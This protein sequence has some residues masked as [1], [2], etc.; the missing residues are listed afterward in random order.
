MGYHRELGPR[1]INRRGFIINAGKAA[2]AAAGFAAGLGA[3]LAIPR[4]PSPDTTPAVAEAEN[5]PLIERLNQILALP[6]NTDERLEKEGTYATW[7]SDLEA[8]DKGLWVLS[9]P[10]QRARLIYK[11]ATLREKGHPTLTRL[12]DAQ[13]AWA[14]KNGIHPETLA[15][16]IDAFDPAKE[17]IEKLK[18]VLR[19]N[20]PASTPSED[21][22]INPGGMA[23]LMVTESG[24]KLDPYP[25]NN[26]LWRGFVSIGQRPAVLEINPDKFPN[27]VPALRKLAENLRKDTGLNFDPENIQ[28]S[29]RGDPQVNDSGGAIGLQF[30][31]NNALKL[32]NMLA[33]VGIKFNPFDIT[34]SLVGGWVFL[35]EQVSFPDGS[36]RYGYQRGNPEAIRFAIEKWNQYDPQIRSIVEAAYDYYDTIIEPSPTR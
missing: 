2:G 28:G 23:M 25:G 22:M 5:P 36:L 8:I 3:G 1:R 7:A 17:A 35:A 31:P 33:S 19:P 24:F 12:S 32:Y 16:C 15:S 30:M 27:A 6:L 11:R 34:S 4:P 29:I 18:K 21:L 20:L 9:R 26:D 14:Q 13:R 10:E